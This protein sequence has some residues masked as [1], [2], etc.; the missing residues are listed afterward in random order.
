[1]AEL[2]SVTEYCKLHG[3]D[4]GNVRRHI[5]AGRIPAR[6]IG[7]QW[8][9]SEDTPPPEDKRVKSGKYINWRKNGKTE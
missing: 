4:G 2:L 1:V 3:L 8:V 5:A 6:K 7:S 9:I